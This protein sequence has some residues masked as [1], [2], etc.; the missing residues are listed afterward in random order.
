MKQKFEA[1]R[2][3]LDE[4]AQQADYSVFVLG[5]TPEEAPYA[6]QCLKGV[7]E[8]RPESYFVTFCEAFVS[9]GEYLDA[10]MGAL[11][12]QLREAELPRRERGEPPFPPLPS[13]LADARRPPPER[14]QGLLRFLPS[15]LPNPR[16]HAVVVAFLP[17]EN[18]D[19]DAYCRLM[20]SLLPVHVV[21]AWMEPLR[22]I[23]Y[24]DRRERQ[25]SSLLRAHKA[26][27]VLTYEIDFSTPALTDALSRDAANPAVP[28]PQ[29]MAC[30]L[31]L[32]ALDFSYQRYPDALEK[33]G[34][35]HTYYQDPPLPA[36]QVLCLQGVGDTLHA[37]GKPEQAKPVLQS[38]IALALEHKALIPL[39][40]AL[41]SIV[42]VCVTLGQHADA[43]SYAQ[44]GMRAAEASMNAP[45]YT[46]LVEKKGDAQLAQGK[47]EEALATYRQ[48][49]ALSEMYEQFS[50]WK[51]VLRKLRVL[52]DGAR[53]SAESAAAERE[54][55]RVEELERRRLAGEAPAPR[56]ASPPASPEPAGA[57]A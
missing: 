57:P 47:R 30:L 33:Y 53:M 24:D 46:A 16:E 19:N 37:A 18:R 1:L 8:S 52:Y 26:E 32:A 42:N 6:V 40:H 25:L 3:N 12:R 28:M 23:L 38:G 2:E 44:S 14:L 54:L 36:M 51:S 31:Q 15:L 43:E 20:A 39:L 11:G 55:Q 4:F 56:P 49:L 5:C 7:D 45:V 9:P 50:V 13:E 35:L 22:I 17:L 21:P 41:L 27:A 34:V 48:C 29:R 10:L